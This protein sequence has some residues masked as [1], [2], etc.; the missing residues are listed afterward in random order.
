MLIITNFY[1]KANIFNDYFADQCKH[2]DNGSS[3]P[4]S[5][6]KTNASISHINITTNYIV[7]IIKKYNTKKAHASDEISVDMMVQLCAAEVAIPL[8]IIFTKCVNTGMFPDSWKYAQ[9]IHTK[10][11][12]QLKSNYRSISLLC[13]CEKIFN[14]IPVARQDFTKHLGVYPDSRL[15]FSK[16]IKEAVIK[17]TKGISLLNIYPNKFLGKY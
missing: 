6:S 2:F 16:H 9:P 17:A 10:G 3:L 11:N 12:R 7:N 8:S 5:L 14:D 4:V 1:Q 15:N 13:I